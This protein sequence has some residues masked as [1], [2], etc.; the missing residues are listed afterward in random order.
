MPVPHHRHR[1]RHQQGQP[2]HGLLSAHL[3]H[4]ADEGIENHHSHKQHVTV[5]AHRDQRRRQDEVEDVEPGEEVPYD[6]L[7]YAAPGALRRQITLAFEVQLR[8][9]LAAEPCER[10]GLIVHAESS[11]LSGAE[12]H[13][14]FNTRGRDFGWIPSTIKKV[15]EKKGPALDARR[16]GME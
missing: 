14:H 15:S 4:G 8:C 7:P 3:L 2:V 6:D 5:G 1:G 10:P 16:P 12:N 9:L 11:F 13:A